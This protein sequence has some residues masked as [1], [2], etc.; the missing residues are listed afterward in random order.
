MDA[1]KIFEEK[2]VKLAE[3]IKD[4][5]AENSQLAEEAKELRTENSNL[6]EENAQL[7]AKLSML[8]KS[9]LDDSRRIDELRQEKELTRLVVDDLIKSIDSLVE[10]QS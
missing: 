3:K 7:A 6:A 1:L 9:L 2:L 8:E 5:L 10:N 4:L